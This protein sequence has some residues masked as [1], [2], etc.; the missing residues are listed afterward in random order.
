MP[1]QSSVYENEL[2]TANDFIQDIVKRLR[3]RSYSLPGELFLEWML[4]D[5]GYRYNDPK[6]WGLSPIRFYGDPYR[7]DDKLE[8]MVI[9]QREIDLE[10]IKEMDR[11]IQAGYD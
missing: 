10:E 6:E 8:E 7:S 3:D 1:Y 5:K 9:R 4:R 2:R 11:I